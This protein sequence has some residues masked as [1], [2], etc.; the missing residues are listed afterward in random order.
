MYLH[1][2]HSLLHDIRDQHPDLKSAIATLS[3]LKINRIDRYIQLCLAGGL[4]CMHGQESQRLT[5]LV[6][7]TGSGMVSTV[8]TLM[9]AL[10]RDHHAPK[11]LQFIRS[12]ANSA[13]YH[14]AR[15][16]DSTAPSIALAQEHFSFEAALDYALVQPAIPGTPSYLLVGG[17]DE[18]PLPIAQ[19][20]TRLG[21]TRKYQSLTEGSHWLL[22]ANE[23]RPGTTLQVRIGHPD[24]LSAAAFAHYCDERLPPDCP[25]LLNDAELA[26]TLGPRSQPLLRPSSQCCPHRTYSGHNMVLAAQLLMQGQHARA[27]VIS[28][29]NHDAYCV[30]TLWRA[31]A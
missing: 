6:L 15:V 9:E 30:T 21:A 10:Y 5:H 27:V 19:H 3:P 13:C 31:L 14:L 7:A 1:A 29:G 18:A 28:R 23:P 22:L 16:L 2:C 12:L 8:A 26:P 17:V 24:Y 25:I 4:H 20:L 11:P